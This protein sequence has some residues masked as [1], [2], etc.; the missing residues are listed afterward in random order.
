MGQARCWF[1]WSLCHEGRPCGHR[2]ATCAPGVWVSCQG[3][4]HLPLF[5]PLKGLAESQVRLPQGYRTQLRGEG[6]TFALC[7]S[8]TGPALAISEQLRW[9]KREERCESLWQFVSHTSK[10]MVG[11]GGSQ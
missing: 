5:H 3:R 1:A 4:P 11:G 10:V 2:E 9:V 8:S 7:S 6:A